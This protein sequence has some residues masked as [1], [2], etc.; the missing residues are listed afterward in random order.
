MCADCKAFARREAAFRKE[1]QV[2]SDP[3]CTRF[4]EPSGEV[5]EYWQDGT[6]LRYSADGKSVQT[7]TWQT[8]Q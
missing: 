2:V 5:I 7:G 1:R 4:F 6:M 3:D 8:K